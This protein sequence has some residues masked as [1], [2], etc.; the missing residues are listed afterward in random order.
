MSIQQIKSEDLRHFVK[1]F[2]KVK[3]D[4]EKFEEGQL[5]SEIETILAIVKE[6][7][8][9]EIQIYSDAQNYAKKL[10]KIEERTKALI[11]S[12]RC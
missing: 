2:T 7:N 12:N 5:E 4:W 10:K 8:E 9:T 1:Q 6:I 3:E 11:N